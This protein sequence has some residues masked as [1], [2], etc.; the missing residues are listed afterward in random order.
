[1]VR[2]YRFYNRLLRMPILYLYCITLII[3]IAAGG[4]WWHF[5]Y[6]PLYSSINTLQFTINNMHCQLHE[7]RK[8]EKALNGISQSIDTQNT[9]KKSVT[10]M[11]NLDAQ[12]SLSLIADSA[13]NAGITMESC[14]LCSQHEEDLFFIN[15]ISG[16]FKGSFDQI[17]SFF[18]TLKKS[19]QIIDVTQCTLIA[20]GTN[21]F[22]F[23]ALFKVY[24]I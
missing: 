24:C 22:C 15:D 18:D 3:I 16:N 10:K 9:Y 1:M 8:T 14:K 11:R 23:H 6:A 17:I 7:L 19:K 21:T 5:L 13:L 2:S 4:L 20:N 12:Q